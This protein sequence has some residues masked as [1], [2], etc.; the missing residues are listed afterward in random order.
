M[1]ALEAAVPGRRE[2]RRLELR[3]RIL[4]E[5][6]ALF[7]TQG[8]ESTTVTEIAERADIAYGTF[9][10]HFPTKSDLL[11]EITEQTMG[12]LF[13][14]VASRHE[15]P[16][17]FEDHLISLFEQSAENAERVGPQLRELLRAMMALTFSQSPNSDDR[18]VRSAF[19]SF[20]SQGRA[21]GA[22]RDDVDLETLTDVVVGTWNAMFLSWVN[23][24]TYPLK[25]RAAAAGRFLAG[26]CCRQR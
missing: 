13:R 3:E 19:R 11:Q 12:E 23:D 9:F 10:N 6:I 26:T 4:Q 17:T 21:S 24:D 5:A 20:L 16:G 8:Y 14:D 2:R 18:R 15:Q 1:S 25:R 7:E 22:L